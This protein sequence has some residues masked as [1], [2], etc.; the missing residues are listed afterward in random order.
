MVYEDTYE[1]IDANMSDSNVGGRKRRN[2]RDNL[3]VIYATI[4]DAIR[5]N[6]KIDIQ[7]YDISKC[8][9]SMWAEDSM[10]DYY[11]VGVTNDKFALISLLNDK[12]K[13]KIKTPVGDTDIFELEQIE[14]QGT[15]TAPLKCSVQMDTL[16]R[17]CYKYS[18]GLYLYKMPA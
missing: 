3:F 12:C 17:Y 6:K 8:F 15:V 5:N 13:V 16:G 10:N 7:Y 4:N 18:T 11:D 14:M 2:I 1:Q 9:D